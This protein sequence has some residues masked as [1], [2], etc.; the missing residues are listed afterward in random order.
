MPI[1][2]YECPKCGARREELILPRLEPLFVFCRPCSFDA[3]RWVEMTKLISAPA[4]A[5][6]KTPAYD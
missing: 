2:E 5:K 1:Y 6:L 4:I 3:R